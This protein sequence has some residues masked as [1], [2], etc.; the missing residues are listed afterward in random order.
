MSFS[1]QEPPERGKGYGQGAASNQ[2]WQKSL[3]NLPIWAIA[4]VH[5]GLPE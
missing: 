4:G 3:F 2:R 5:D 1:L